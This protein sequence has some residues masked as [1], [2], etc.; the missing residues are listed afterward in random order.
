MF[1]QALGE[2]AILEHHSGVDP[3]DVGFKN[4]LASENWDAPIV[5]TTNV[6]LFE[7]L[8]ASKTSSCR[9]LHNV[10][11]SVII[12]DEAQMLSPDYLMPTLEAL[13]ELVNGYGCTVVLCTATQ[14]A[15]LKTDDFAD[16]VEN[17]REIIKNPRQLY[18]QFRRVAV[19][20]AAGRFSMQDISERI[21]GHRQVLCIVNRRK[22]AMEIYQALGESDGNFHLSTFM[23][24]EHRSSTLQLIR[25]RLAQGQ[26]C[27]VVSTQ[28][29]E[30]G[31]DVDFP[32]VYRAEAG[33]DSIAQAAG[34]CNREGKMTEGGKVMVFQLETRP[35]V[36]LLKQSADE[37]QKTIRKH[38]DDILS[39]DAVT[40]Y[41]KSFYWKRRNANGLDKKNIVK[42]LASG[43]A[44]Q[45]VNIPFRDVSRAYCII[46]NNTTSVVVPWAAGEQMARDL[47]ESGVADRFILRKLQRYVVQVRQE[48]RDELILAG[49][50]EDIFGDGTLFRL[51]NKNIYD[52]KIGLNTE[53]SLS[54]ETT[55]LFV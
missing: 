21:C 42:Q 35:P 10:A 20:V 27:R 36:G 44:S 50:I 32:V 51:I 29:I 15:L 2:Q 39:L 38:N 47:A 12:V 41:F 3:E 48:I 7:S 22:D 19:E 45:S 17:V 14:P 11:N 54:Y 43:A 1:R 5:V 6:Q 49:C 16:G 53:Q 33:I 24:A 26:E 52:D 8:F 13:K 18:E 46:E 25:E 28:L 30:A 55:A 23:C 31:V 34:R 37:G 9:K 40:D 4:K